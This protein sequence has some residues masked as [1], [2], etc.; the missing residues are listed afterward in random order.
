MDFNVLSA[1]RPRYVI[2]G[3]QNDPYAVRSLLGWHINGSIEREGNNVVQCHRIQIHKPS[4]V[5]EASG[6]VVAER[7]VKEQLT[8][9]V[10]ERM[11][12]LDFSEKENGTAMSQEDR[13]FIRKAKEGIHHRED[14]HYG[15]PLPFRGKNFQFLNNRP[16]AVQ[17]LV[18]LKKNLK[19]MKC[20]LLIMSIL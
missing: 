9:R 11:F 14:L 17:R 20:T 2:H 6:Y 1:V 18:G 8:P 19:Q 3:K 7:S 16:Q 13:E 15:M 10:V 12:E 5:N 4:A